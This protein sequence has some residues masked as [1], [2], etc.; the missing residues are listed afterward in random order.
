MSLSGLT[1]IPSPGMPTV[2]ARWLRPENRRRCDDREA[3]PVWLGSPV[4]QRSEGFAEDLPDT[5]ALLPG[6]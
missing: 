2:D 1:S 6:G 5:T 3:Q 4:C